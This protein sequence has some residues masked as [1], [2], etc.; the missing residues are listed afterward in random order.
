MSEQAALPK[1]EKKGKRL[2]EVPETLLKRRKLR[3][4]R[5]AKRARIAIEKRKKL[6]GKGKEAFKRAEKYVKEYRASERQQ[7]RLRRIAKKAPFPKFYVPPEQKV[8]IVIRIRGI[9][10]LH[11]KPRKVLQLLRLRQINN[12]TF[13]R[14]NKATINMLRIAE[15]YIAYGFPSLSTVRSL[16]YK[17]GFAKVNGQRIAISD[18]S[19]VEKRLKKYNMVCM[20]DLVHEIFTCGPNFRKAS[21]F[22]WPFKLSNPNGGWRDKGRHYVDGGDF[23]NREHAINYLLKRM[24]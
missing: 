20:E 6:S 12:A 2:P 22:F 23:G 24:V 5:K 10:G 17:R 13:V 16:I 18:N 8:A 9:N 14:L 1:S 19:I 15:P 4:E 11:P 21:R 3:D 7:I